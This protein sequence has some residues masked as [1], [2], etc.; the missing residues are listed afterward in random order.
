LSISTDTINWTFRTTGYTSTHW[1]IS[2][3]NDVYVLATGSGIRTSTDTIVWT[4]RFSTTGD[5]VSTAFG[6][7]IHLVGARERIVSYSPISE[8]R[9]GSAGNGTRGGGGAGGSY[10][11]AGNKFGTGGKGGDGYVRITWW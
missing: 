1:D 6:N 5:H 8:S 2:Y 9:I 3:G 11:P 10:S 4:Q 7:G